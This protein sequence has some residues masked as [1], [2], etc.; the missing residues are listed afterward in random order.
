MHLY[1]TQSLKASAQPFITWLM[2]AEEEDG[3]DDEGEEGSGSGE[4]EED[5]DEGS[6][7]A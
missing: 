3:S 4:D 1:L 5:D 2:E 6:D 7:E